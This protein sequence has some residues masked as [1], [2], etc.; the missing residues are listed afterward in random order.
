MSAIFRTAENIILPMVAMRGLFVTFLEVRRSSSRRA[1]PS[2]RPNAVRAGSPLLISRTYR[3]RPSSAARPPRPP[4]LT[5]L[6]IL[7]TTI[8]TGP[9]SD[10]S[11]VEIVEPETSIFYP[12]SQF[13]LDHPIH[14]FSLT[15]IL[16]TLVL[17]TTLTLPTVFW[18]RNRLR[19]ATKLVE[20]EMRRLNEELAPRVAGES[21]RKG[22]DYDGYRAELKRQV[23]PLTL[24]SD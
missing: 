12:L 14:S 20:P 7:S 21:K 11:S 5:N 15:I 23:G 2:F 10:P 3:S 16:I 8:L 17:R 24:Q 19:R 4:R 22:L 6:P 1:V 18:A 13:L 9:P